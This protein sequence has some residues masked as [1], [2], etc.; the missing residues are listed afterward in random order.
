[1]KIWKYKWWVLLGII[2][3]TGVLSYSNKERVIQKDCGEHCYC[4]F[5]VRKKSIFFI[6]I[7][8]KQS[9]LE[10]VCH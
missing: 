1:M 3:L 10:R 8:N 9:F 2:L 4:R 6:T 5:S 7:E